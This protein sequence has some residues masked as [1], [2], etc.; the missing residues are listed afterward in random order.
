MMLWQ[1]NVCR[2]IWELWNFKH[3]SRQEAFNE[4]MEVGKSTE[5]GTQAQQT[6]YNSMVELYGDGWLEVM[7][8]MG[9][10]KQHKRQKV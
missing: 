3:W 4:V 9:Q 1:K 7:S 8:P 2:K 5:W 10:Q 6:I